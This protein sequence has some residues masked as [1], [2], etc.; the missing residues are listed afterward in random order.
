MDRQQRSGAHSQKWLDHWKR[1]VANYAASREHV[2]LTLE[3]VRAVVQASEMGWRRSVLRQ[4]TRWTMKTIIKRLRRLDE[5]VAAP[6]IVKPNWAAIL[7]GK[8]RRGQKRTGRHMQ[9]HR[10]KRLR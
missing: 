1:Q 10:E 4:W 8:Q 5:I 3:G 7:A 6:D 2:P 9:N